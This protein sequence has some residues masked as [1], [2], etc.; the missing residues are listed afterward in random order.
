M[1]CGF[2][3]GEVVGPDP[4]VVVATG[5]KP[6]ELR[7]VYIGIAVVLLA[8]LLPHPCGVQFQDLSVEMTILTTG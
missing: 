7:L 2:T 3:V 6:A 1:F 4:S 5:T 8:D